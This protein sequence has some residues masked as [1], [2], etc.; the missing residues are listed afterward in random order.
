MGQPTR[1]QD[2]EPPSYDPGVQQS[3]SVIL[4]NILSVKNTATMIQN[5]KVGN[6]HQCILSYVTLFLFYNST[7]LFIIA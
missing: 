3:R 2:L 4:N 5:K 7:V 1:Y 6:Y